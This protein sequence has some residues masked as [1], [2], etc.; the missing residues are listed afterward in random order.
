MDNVRELMA[1]RAALL[2]QADAILKAALDEGRATTSE[3]NTR[4]DELMLQAKALQDT[5]ER[6]DR[7]RNLMAN[8]E[9]AAQV[10]RPDPVQISNE[11][12]RQRDELHAIALY[13]RRGD[14]S[15][16]MDLY[17]VSN[18]TDM[19]IGTPADGGYAVPT[20]HYQGIIAKRDAMSLVGPLGLLRIPGIGT[21]VNVPYDNGT[22]NQF[23]STNEAANFDRDAPA[24]GLAAMTLVKY[25][26]KVTLS[27]ELLNDEDSNLTAFLNDYVGRAAGLTYN[28]L[29]FTEVL[30]N[31]TSV[32]WRRRP[33]H[34]PA[35]RRR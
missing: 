8:L 14:T 17:A 29:L 24:L 9:H 5:V 2:G 12:Q 23:V 27:D 19:N 32:R 34:R 31:G 28:A 22:A 16:L 1:K 30:A 15:G 3:E 25:T 6:A 13:V 11:A 21:T 10:R 18:D 7:S 4:V 26:K 35:I 20:G 33:R